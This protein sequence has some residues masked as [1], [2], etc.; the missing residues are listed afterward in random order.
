MIVET[1]ETVAAVGQADDIQ[2]WRPDLGLDPQTYCRRAPLL[3]KLMDALTGALAVEGALPVLQSLELNCRLTRAMLM[4]LARSLARGTVP[5]LQNLILC[6]ELDNSM[7]KCLADTLER[8]AS[9]VECKRIEHFGVDMGKGLLA[10]QVRLL[11]VLLPS[12]KKIGHLVWNS[13]FEDCFREVQA[14]YLT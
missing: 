11:H 8:R 1:E 12:V 4:K 13:A 2:G 5:L 7:L 6:T 9:I 14:P 3:P 10:T